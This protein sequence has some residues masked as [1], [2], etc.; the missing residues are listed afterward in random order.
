MATD[1]LDEMLD[2]SA[3]ATARP[4]PGDIRAMILAAREE[5]QP[6]RRGRRRAVLTAA[7]ALFLVGGAGVAAASSDW[8]WSPGLEDA[9]RTYSYTSPTWGQCELRFSVLDTHDMFTN[10][11]V[12]RIVDDWFASTDVEAA[13]APLVPGIL[14]E[15]EESRAGDPAVDPD[16]R[17]AD[18]DAWTAHTQAVDEL[19][20][21]ELAANGFASEALG[22]TES[23]SQVHCDG[24]DWGDGE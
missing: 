12:N 23:H 3:P 10:D 1:P 13:A 24:E 4:E 11:E 18:L 22:G 8:L 21:A 7:L 16:P 17:Q 2:R 20:H 15:L 9:D 6:P 5:T 19:V 14:R